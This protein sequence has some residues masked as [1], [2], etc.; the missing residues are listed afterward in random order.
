MSRS[1]YSPRR[2]LQPGA[3]SQGG[4]WGLSCSPTLTHLLWL[5]LCCVRRGRVSAA[6]C[7]GLALAVNGGS[8]AACFRVDEQPAALAG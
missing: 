7:A 2:Q 1:M 3:L 6:L 5:E 8:C 4:C